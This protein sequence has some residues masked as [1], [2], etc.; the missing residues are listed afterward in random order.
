[1]ESIALPLV[2]NIYISYISVAPSS[3]LLFLALLIFI[4]I[5]LALLAFS[6]SGVYQV[7]GIYNPSITRYITSTQLFNPLYIISST[8]IFFLVSAALARLLI[9]QLIQA[10]SQPITLQ[11]NFHDVLLIY[12]HFVLYTISRS[13]YSSYSLLF[14]KST[15]LSPNN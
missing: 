6:T 15:F 12:S 2:Q 4:I 11:Q 8:S 7:R 5:Y 13:L 10:R 3:Y 14:I 1:M 9:L